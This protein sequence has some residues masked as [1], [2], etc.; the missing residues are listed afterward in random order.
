MRFGCCLNMVASYTDG[1]GIE[2]IEKLAELGYEYA[3]LPLAEMMM[4]SEEKFNNLKKRVQDSGIACEVCNNFF[5]K[6]MRLTGEEVH[7]DMILTYAEKALDRAHELGV[8]YVVFGS[9]PAKNVPEGYSLENGYQQVV[10]LLKQV[11]EIARNRGITIV[12]EPLRKAECNLINTFK[13]GCGLAADVNHECVK[14]LVDFYH[15]S[16]EKEPLT[17]ILENG[18]QFLRHVHFANPN[19]RVYPESM[20]E[21]DYQAFFAALREIEYNERISCEAYCENFALSAS[22]TLKVFREN[23]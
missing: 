16:E 4:L 20:V 18:K 1:T 14:V 10:N 21:A 8:R 13:E 2:H 15:L 7:M 6:T 3:E 9:G 5:P 17:N 23:A 19:G 11:G 22:K 12:I